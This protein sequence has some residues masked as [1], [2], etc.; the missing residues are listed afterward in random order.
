[1]PFLNKRSSDISYDFSSLSNAK[2]SILVLDKNWHNMF[3]PGRK[4]ERM[5]ELEKEL[6]DLLKEQGG[7]TNKEKEYTRFKKEC[8]NK[9]VALMQDAYE[10]NDESAKSDMTKS[11]RYIE[12]INYKLS[13]IEERLI[14]LPN[15][16]KYKNRL[17]LEESLKQCYEEMRTNKERVTQ[18]E[19][20]ISDL[21]EKLRDRI[22][23]KAVKEEMIERTYLFL[24]N[25]VGASIINK[26]DKQILE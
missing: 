11:Q 12:E 22:D 20:E 23:E 21:R 13:D 25:I 6:N 19:L 2:I 9:I 26:L 15:E 18:L 4:T 1:M 3:P 5:L 16:I 8:M 14:N 17:L 10:S 7:L 24:H